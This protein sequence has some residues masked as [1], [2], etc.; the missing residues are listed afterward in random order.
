MFCAWYLLCASH[1]S[2]TNIDIIIVM[3]IQLLNH[4]LPLSLLNIP[5]YTGQAFVYLGFDWENCVTGPFFFSHRLPWADMIVHDPTFILSFTI[6]ILMSSPSQFCF[7]LVS[8][9]VNFLP[10]LTFKKYLIQG[11]NSFL[12]SF[13]LQPPFFFHVFFLSLLIPLSYLLTDASCLA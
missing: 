2:Y 10:L 6:T 1:E 3:E 9:L 8:L 11:T 5:L 4:S 13:F 7:R 12:I